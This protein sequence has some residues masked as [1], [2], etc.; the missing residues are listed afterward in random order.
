MLRIESSEAGLAWVA[1]E[2]WKRLWVRLGVVAWRN[3]LL[4]AWQIELGGLEVREE[5]VVR[6]RRVEDS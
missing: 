6:L 4:H 2:L 3:F 5:L 1:V